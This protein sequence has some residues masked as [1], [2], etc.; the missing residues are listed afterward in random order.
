MTAR[1]YSKITTE[2]TEFKLQIVKANMTIIKLMERN[3][4]TFS[5]FSPIGDKLVTSIRL[6]LVGSNKKG[7][8]MQHTCISIPA[9]IAFWNSKSTLTRSLGSSSFRMFTTKSY[10][11][12]AIGRQGIECAQKKDQY[13]MVP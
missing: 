8:G 10:Q 2:W 3:D 7:A 9:S 6:I 4:V 11:L 13:S 1:V 5:F 12:Y